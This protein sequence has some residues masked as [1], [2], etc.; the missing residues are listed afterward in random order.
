MGQTTTQG[1]GGM[2]TVRLHCWVRPRSSGGYVAEC[3]E[4]GMYFVEDTPQQAQ[5]NLRKPSTTMNEL[6]SYS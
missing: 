6:L 1:E 3:L 2:R 4:L 5:A